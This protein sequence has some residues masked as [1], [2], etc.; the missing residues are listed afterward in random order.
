MFNKEEIVGVIN[1]LIESNGYRLVEVSYKLE[2]GNNVL[3]IVVDRDEVISISD[4][5]ALNDIISPALD[6][7]EFLDEKYYLDVSSLGIEKPID[8]SKIDNYVGQYVNLHL[9]TPYEG[10]NY[11]E[12]EIVETDED[13]VVL[14][15]QI[16]S[17]FKNI[18]FKKRL[19]DKGRLAIKF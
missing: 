15:I 1:P 12:G 4:I 14:K 9:S 3:H 18:S 6:S 11:V 5:V 8:V 7:I 16:K 2:N 13:K 17:K 10:E 19:I